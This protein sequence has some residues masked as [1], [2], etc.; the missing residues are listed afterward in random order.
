VEKNIQTEELDAHG[1][2]GGGG[3][4][5]AHWTERQVPLRH[6]LCRR[7]VLSLGW[8][9]LVLGVEEIRWERCSRRQ[10]PGLS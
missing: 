2:V 4:G 10:P 1:M 6:L 9:L 5:A 8:R 7:E 3:W